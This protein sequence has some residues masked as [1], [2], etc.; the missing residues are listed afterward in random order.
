MPSAPQRDGHPLLPGWGHRRHLCGTSSVQ[1]GMER[2]MEWLLLVWMGPC[3]SW[4]RGWEG[5]WQ[6]QRGQVSLH[7]LCSG[8]WDTS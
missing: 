2:G 8:F 5:C 4:C 6:G 7:E 3:S 1:A